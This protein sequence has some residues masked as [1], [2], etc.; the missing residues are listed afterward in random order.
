MAMKQSM[1][2]RTFAACCV[3]FG[4]LYASGFRWYS[5]PTAGMEPTL[6]KGS[7][8]VGHLT[9]SYRSHIERFQI[10]I[11]IP[12]ESPNQLYAKRVIGLPGEHVAVTS[13][14]ITIN[15]ASLA[16]PSS[17]NVAGLGVKECDVAVPKD[18]V[19][20]LGDNTARS[21]D[22]RYVGPIP[23]QNVVGR[24]LFKK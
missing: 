24:I 9:E 4:L 7:H 23:T 15:G 13:K 18:C 16:L 14:G 20:V 10:A 22:S 17:V 3:A 2:A 6:P 5:F 21:A 11:Y 8:A 19:F 12:R 1:F